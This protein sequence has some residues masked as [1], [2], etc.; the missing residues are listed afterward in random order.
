MSDPGPASAARRGLRAAALA[1]AVVAI[2]GGIAATRAALSARAEQADGDA[3]L[4]RGD[5]RLAI[6][7]YE[8]AARLRVPGLASQ[9]RAL[10]RLETVAGRAEARG[11]AATAR[12]ALEAARRALYASRA[13]GVADPARLARLDARLAVLLARAD[14][15]PGDEAARRAWHAAALARAEA[16]AP[17]FAALAILGFALWAGG[18]AAFALR[19]LG[20]DL[21]VRPRAAAV[22]AG[23]VVAGLALWVVGL[24]KA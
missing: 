7:A 5:V 23:A 6:D 19:G 13:A 24:W 4:G 10:D 9:A 14:P 2:L 16:P 17:G 18:G 1:G 3:A 21:R 8:R 22:A 12:A 20:P 15:G 11:D